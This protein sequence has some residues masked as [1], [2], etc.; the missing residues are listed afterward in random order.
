MQNF[1]GYLLKTAWTFGLSAVFCL[2][3]VGHL[4]YVQYWIWIRPPAP[5]GGPRLV[6]PLAQSGRLASVS[7][8]C[9]GLV[10]VNDLGT[11][12]YEYYCRV[13]G[14]SLIHI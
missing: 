7:I 11:Q 9:A 13:G 12:A 1:R 4:M 3:P 14:L 8:L 5:A 10:P 6:C 2:S